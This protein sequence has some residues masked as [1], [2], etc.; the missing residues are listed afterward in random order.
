MTRCEPDESDEKETVLYDL[1]PESGQ[2]S[3]ESDK[4]DKPDRMN[5][6]GQDTVPGGHKD[7]RETVKTIR[8]VRA[9]VMVLY[10]RWNV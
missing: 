8:S 2:S 3:P 4:N 1:Q 6:S 5:A 10:T 7:D 9:T